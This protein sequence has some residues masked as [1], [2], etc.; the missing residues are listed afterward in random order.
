MA[1]TWKYPYPPEGTKAGSPSFSPEEAVVCPG[2]QITFNCTVVDSLGTQTTIWNVN[3]TLGNELCVLIHAINIGE[4]CTTGTGDGLIVEV[5]GDC[6]SSTLH[7]TVTQDLD[8]AVV[9][10]FS[11]LTVDSDLAGSGILKLLDGNLQY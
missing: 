10:C 8:N 1:L 9:Q 4:S 2:D 7:L 5:D 3:T 11:P 6:Y